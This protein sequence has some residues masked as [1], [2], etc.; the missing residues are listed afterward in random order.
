MKFG[1]VVFPGSNCDRDCHYAVQEVLGS[2]TSW[3]W[4]GERSLGAVDAVIL[5]GGFSY[6]DYLR[7]GAMARSSPVM[8]AVA[9]FAEKGGLVLGICN[10]FQILCEAGLLPGVLLPNTSVQFRCEQTTLSVTNVN[11]PFTQLYHRGE[12]IRMPVAH[13]MGNYFVPEEVANQLEE[14]R[15]VVFRYVNEK[16]ETTPDSNPNGSVHHIAGVCNERGNVLGLMPHP[17]RACEEW[18]GSED[19]LRIFASTLRTIGGGQK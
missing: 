19:G 4:H 16:G 15:Q 13:G 7:A 18:M 12:V 9:S 1:I 10:G 8:D 17:E 5:P 3:I 14:K 2:E 11:R 6:G